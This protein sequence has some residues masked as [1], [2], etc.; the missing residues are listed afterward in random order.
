[1]SR[2]FEAGDRILLFDSK[3]RRY[4]VTLA[5]GGE[6]HTHSGPCHMMRCSANPKE[7]WFGRRG[8]P[9]TPQCARRWPRWC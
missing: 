7:W 2:V 9:A 5:Q 6:F 3:D 8:A 1:M 4:L